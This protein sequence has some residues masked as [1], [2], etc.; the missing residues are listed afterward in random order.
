M[1]SLSTVSCLPP[2]P[3]RPASAEALPPGSWDTHIHAIGSVDRFPLAAGRA[4][5]PAAC[6]ISQ[7]MA[8][9]DTVGV[10]K[11]VLVQP[12][13]YGTDNSAMLHTMAA[14][15]DRFAGVAVVDADISD[16]SLMSMHKIGVRGIRVNLAYRGGLS[17]AGARRLSARI[18]DLGWHVQVLTTLASLD[19]AESL[20]T[21]TD[22]VLD[23]FGF[24]DPTQGVD[25]PDF[26]RLLVLLEKGRCWLKL[27]APYRLATKTGP[28][29]E[30]LTPFVNALV[31]ANPERLIWG[32]DWPHTDLYQDMP[33]DGKLIR[34]LSSWVPSEEARQKILVTNP[35]HLYGP[36]EP[37]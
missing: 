21:T 24:L 25:G 8:F 6:E 30:D 20:T 5:T 37:V 1:N 15:P 12:S 28:G 33:D 34:A 22:I 17:I 13:F 26:Q 18:A 31:K 23:H 14:Y 16:T 35:A 36:I 11:A 27:S 10:R 32:S 2:L 3:F 29:Y 4:Y 7:Y 9:M 19:E